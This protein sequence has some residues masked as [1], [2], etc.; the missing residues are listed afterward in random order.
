MPNEFQLARLCHTLPQKLVPSL[1]LTCITFVCLSFLLPAMASPDVV[2]SALLLPTSAASLVLCVC[3]RLVH[4]PAPVK[5]ALLILVAILAAVAGG[6]ALSVAC[7]EP[8]R[9]VARVFTILLQATC[10]PCCSHPPLTP[11]HE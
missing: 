4:R 2:A 7:G 1:S 11:S 5:D 3:N 8:L 6:T 9:A 10:K